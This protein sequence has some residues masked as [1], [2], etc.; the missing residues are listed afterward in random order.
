MTAVL[1][2]RVFKR[3][4]RER[5]RKFMGKYEHGLDSKLSSKASN[6]FHGP[7]EVDTS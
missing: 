7:L 4:P 3:F 1:P 5:Y 2:S 6:S